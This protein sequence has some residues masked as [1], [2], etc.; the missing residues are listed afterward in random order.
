MGDLPRNILKPGPLRS[1]L[2]RMARLGYAARGAVYIGLG[3]L[4]M[5]AALDVVPRARGA[6]AMLAAWAAWPPG[7]VLI[8]IVAAGLAGFAAWRSLQAVFDADRHGNSPKAFAI[9]AGQALSGAI[10][11]GLAWSALELLDEIEDVGEADEEQTADAT[12]AAI[13]SLPYGDTLLLLAGV[14]LM[15]A[16]VGGIVQGVIQ[17]FAKRLDCRP[18]TCRRLV[19][20]ARC[21]YVARGSTTLLVGLFFSIAGLH[22]RAGEARSL[23][24]ALQSLEAQPLGS[25]LLGLVALGLVAFGVFGF[26]EAFY[27]RIRPPELD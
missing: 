20:L 14:M 22:A 5:L 21:G 11:A 2:E 1:L 26:A 4:A 16:G 18:V 27:R 23:G 7:V 25:S 6:T 9:R 17:D 3:C 12:A 24:G 19:P 13:L 10:Y 15:G 8:A